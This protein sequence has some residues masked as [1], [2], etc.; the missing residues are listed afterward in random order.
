M[1]GCGLQVVQPGKFFPPG[2][3][4]DNN[5]PDDLSLTIRKQGKNPAEIEVKQGDQS[6]TVKEGDLSSLPDDVRP[7]VEAMLGH[8]LPFKMHFAM[9]SVPHQPRAVQLPKA[10]VRAGPASATGSTRPS[11]P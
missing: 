10:P 9:P 6:W 5:L 4:F 2:F 8:G 3:R 1:K 7:H 11:R